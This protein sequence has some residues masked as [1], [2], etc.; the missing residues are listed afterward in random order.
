[1][2]TNFLYSLPASLAILKDEENL[3]VRAG[4][5][6]GGAFLGLLTAVIR[7]RRFFGKSLYT[8]IGAGLFT[9]A[10]YPD[11]AVQFGK[12]L[13]DESERLGKIAVNFVQGVQPGD[14]KPPAKSD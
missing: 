12:D 9:A 8:A 4:F 5:I 6:G 13:A 2:I 10:L 11:D 1:M 3:P 14:V 7:R